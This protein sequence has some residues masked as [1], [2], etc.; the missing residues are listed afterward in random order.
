MRSVVLNSG[1]K[2]PLIGLGT[3]RLR[4]PECT[5]AVKN[6]LKLGYRH[7]DT[8]D[9]YE[10]HKDVALALTESGLEREELFITSKVGPQDLRYDDLLKTGER[11]LKELELAYLDLLLIHW[12]NSSIPL[13][14]TL[15]AMAELKGAGKVKNI[16]V[17]NFTRTH[18][19]EGL[20]HHPGLISV[21]QVEF[22][23]FLYQKDLLN[24]CRRENIV[25]TAYSPLARGK[26]F[27]D[28]KITELAEKYGRTPAQL[29]LR[30]LLEKEI[31]VIP[32]ASSQEHL[33]D[34]INALQGE[35]PEEVV[36]ILD[37]LNRNERIINPDFAEFDR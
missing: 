30:W 25:L 14:Q 28:P 12:P 9:L 10:N 35:M 3:W 1:Q 18:I 6:S 33:Q 37:S 22:H 31:V 15:Q 13:M 4:G 24:Y 7:I 16:G 17:S 27:K 29:V 36:A 2:M 5:Q 11:I 19:A 32:K 34:N 8:A 21:N 20:Q 26:V 23:P